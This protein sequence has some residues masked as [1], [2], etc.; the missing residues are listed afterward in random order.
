MLCFLMNNGNH[1][2]KFNNLVFDIYVD[3]NINPLDKRVDCA[4][5]CFAC[6]WIGMDLELSKIKHHIGIGIGNV[7]INAG[8]RIFLGRKYHLVGKCF[9]GTNNAIFSVENISR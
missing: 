7:D 9:F 3:N 4:N 2:K 6:H 8:Y 5:G 1:A